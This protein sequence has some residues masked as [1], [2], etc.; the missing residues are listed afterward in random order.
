MTATKVQV[1]PQ[2]VEIA[3][4]P[5][6][7][8]DHCVFLD[9]TTVCKHR[10]ITVLLVED[11]RSSEHATIRIPLC[12]YHVSRLVGLLADDIACHCIRNPLSH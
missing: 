9:I 5:P 4:Y 3:Q 2:T 8:H 10:A 1:A 7:L 11:H 6:A 12:L